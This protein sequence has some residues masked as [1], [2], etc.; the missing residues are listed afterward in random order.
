MYGIF[1]ARMRLQFSY[2]C[3]T[4]NPSYHKEL[5]KKCRSLDRTKTPPIYRIPL[6]H[7]TRQSWGREDQ[8]TP[9]VLVWG[10]RFEG[11]SLFA[12]PLLRLWPPTFWTAL[13]P[14]VTISCIYIIIISRW[15]IHFISYR[16]SLV[17]RYGWGF[18]IIG[19]I[20]N[21]LDLT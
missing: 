13:L 20:R 18:A 17:H 5:K 10:S 16:F 6:H 21:K 2:F 19:P 12:S 3:F 7:Q 1:A 8:L 14:L 9:H 11:W 4:S 15:L